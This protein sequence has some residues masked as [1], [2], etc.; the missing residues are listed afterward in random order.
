[1]KYRKV[2]NPSGLGGLELQTLSYR[3]VGGYQVDN[4]YFELCDSSAGQF[5]VNSDELNGAPACPC[6]GN[7]FGLAVCSC[8][9]IHCIGDEEIST[10][11]WCGSQGK[12]GTGEGGFD[13]N[14]AQG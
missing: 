13:V 3:M 2:L 12:Y 8:T 6:C 7:Q 11:P 1:M 9:K 14:R 4:S 5:K 10:C